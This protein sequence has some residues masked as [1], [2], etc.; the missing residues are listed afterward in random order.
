MASATVK[1]HYLS[2]RA[3][4]EAGAN[5]HGA[6]VRDASAAALRLHLGSMYEVTV[7]PRDLRQLWLED[8][9]AVHPE[10]YLKPETPSDG[11][12]WFDSH[13]RVFLQQKGIRKP[14]VAQLGCQPDLKIKNLATGKVYYIECKAQ[15][16]AGNA[17]ERCAKYA[18]PSV[19]EAIKRR[20]SIDYHPMGYLFSGELVTK[21]KYILELEGTYRFA[22]GHLL[23]WK[24]DRPV[25][26]IAAWFDTTIR[27]LL[28]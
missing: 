8:D 22:P 28:E 2:T 20:H 9:Y 11:D 7:E 24:P 15:G 16:D 17:H 1:P 14:V 26:A 10:R 23:L 4:W 25:D 19:L 3:N 21:L 13:S 6:S 5:T 18:S 12:I 27:P